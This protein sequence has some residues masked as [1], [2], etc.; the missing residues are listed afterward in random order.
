MEGQFDCT[1]QARMGYRNTPVATVNTADRTAIVRTSS[2]CTANPGVKLRWLLQ[3]K[4]TGNIADPDTALQILA[5]PERH[6]QTANCLP[7]WDRQTFVRLKQS[8][9]LKR[10]LSR[11]RLRIASRSCVFQNGATCIGID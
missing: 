4:Q 5:K 8:L 10:C 1:D 6:K 9:N 3:K 11:N 2:N 7:N